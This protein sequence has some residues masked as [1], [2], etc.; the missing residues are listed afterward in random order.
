[1]KKNFKGIIRGIGDSLDL[2]GQGKVRIKDNTTCEDLS[3][4]MMVPSAV[5][6]EKLHLA[7]LDLTNLFGLLG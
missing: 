5:A 6:E 4:R 3:E 1:M 2:G 7:N